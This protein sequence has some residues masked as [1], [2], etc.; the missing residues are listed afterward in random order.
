MKSLGS[1]VVSRGIRGHDESPIPI[2]KE[3]Q[4]RGECGIAK[5]LSRDGQPEWC[6]KP[7][8]HTEPCNCDRCEAEPGFHHGLDLCAE[9]YDELQRGKQ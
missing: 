6:G 8:V 3:Q 9:H 1:A 2:Q 5:R 7:S 4:M